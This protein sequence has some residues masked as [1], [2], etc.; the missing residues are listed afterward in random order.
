M[1]QFILAVAAPLLLCTFLAPSP[2]LAFEPPEADHGPIA[3]WPKGAPG[4]KEHEV[5]KEAYRP[6]KDGQKR[7]ARLGNVSDPDIR[8]YAA[9]KDK[10][11]GAAVVVC[12]GGG[13]HILA[14]DLEGTEVC[15]W[16][17]AIGVTGVL[18]KYRVP[19][20][21][22]RPAHEAP[23]Q[24]AQRAVR[25]T[26]AHADDWNIDPDRLGILGFSAGGHLAA[27]A[28]TN[29]DKTTY[30]PVD[31]ADRLSARPDFAVLVYPA[32]LVAD[33]T[34]ERPEIAEG[35][36]VTENTPPTFLI[37]TEDDRFT[38]S[39]LFYTFALRKAGVP[40]EL[41]VYPTG[42]HGY[43]LRPSEHSVCTWPK[44]CEDWM[45]KRGLLKR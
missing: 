38:P 40:V 21:K 1:R 15:E 44:R 14:M 29:F 9:P 27:A 5:V 2:A 31:E 42:G 17:N 3:L 13:Y 6:Q 34:A 35:L 43:G 7:V 32:Y 8:V 11:T 10:A 12:P 19:R 33:E 45:R 41:H 37:S 18:L 36:T 39:A 23:L 22:G 4:E 16:L 26:R 20:R 24:D 30:E 25:L 28:S